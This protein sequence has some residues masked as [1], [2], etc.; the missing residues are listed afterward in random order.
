MIKYDIKKKFKITKRVTL[1]RNYL[2]K[3]LIADSKLISLI[4][5]SNCR[6]LQ[7][8]YKKT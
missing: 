8:L 7:N 3:K 6:S 2:L 5:K 4:N 1:Q